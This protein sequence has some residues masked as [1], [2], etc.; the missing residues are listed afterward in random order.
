MLNTCA[1]RIETEYNFR[2]SELEEFWETEGDLSDYGILLEYMALGSYP[3]QKE[4]YFRYQIS[5][6]TIHDEWRFFCDPKL[7]PLKIEY[8][9]MDSGEFD[10]AKKEITG[11][12]FELLK[13]FF[14]FIDNMGEVKR[15]LNEKH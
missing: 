15:A 5:K 13:N 8:V 1:E 6:G 7:T 14:A 12:D 3:G 2:M 10:A 9:L 4:P 11:E